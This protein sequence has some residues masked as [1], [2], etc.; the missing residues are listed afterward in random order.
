[1]ARA[2]DISGRT[3]S[4]PV[5]NIDTDQIIPARFL[6]TT[7]RSGLGKACFYDWRFHEDGRERDDHALK[8]YRPDIF[9]VLVTGSNFGCGSS[10]EQI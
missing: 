2:F 8:G 7:E 5:D 4:L 9:P 10:R 3:F 1:M 6:T